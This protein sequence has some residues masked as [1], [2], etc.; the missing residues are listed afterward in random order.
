[1]CDINRELAL[2]HQSS[3][4]RVFEGLLTDP[5]AIVLVHCAAGKDRTGFAAALILLALGVELDVVMQDYLLTQRYFL[6]HEQI[7][8]LR[9]KYGFDGVKDEVLEP[10]V[11]TRREYL[12][13][14]VDAMLEHSGSV[15]GYLLDAFGVGA[16]ER[17]LLSE[18][19]T[20][21]V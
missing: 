8:A 9:D 20:E 11:A 10:I 12:Q 5:D 17:Q 1:M 6:P 16:V 18:R 19:L 2:S 3:F 7:P 14:G 15:E 4:K 21:T 13:A